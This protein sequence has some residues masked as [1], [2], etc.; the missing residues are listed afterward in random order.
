MELFL[1]LQA[2]SS[3]DLS[4]VFYLRAHK[5]AVNSGSPGWEWGCEGG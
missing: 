4:L 3:T 2:E 1:F 5:H